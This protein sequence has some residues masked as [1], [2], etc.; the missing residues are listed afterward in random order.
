MIMEDFEDKN[1]PR[2]IA[3]IMDGNGR[4][5]KKHALGR[6][7]GHRK[8]AEAVRRTVRACRNWGIK[9]LTLFAFSSE[10]WSRPAKEVNALM[11][12]LKEYIASEVEEIRAHDI[13]LNVIGEWQALRGDIRLLVEDAMKKTAQNDAMIW[14][15]ALSY[16]GRGEIVEAARRIGEDVAQGRILPKDIDQQLFTRYLYTYNLPDPDLLIRTSGEYRISNFLLWQSAYTEFYF[17]DVL[18]PDFS[19]E[20]LMAAIREYQRRERRFGQTTEQLKR[21]GE[22]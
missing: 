21:R 18:W 19:E 22:L 7:A 1:L 12:L 14:T 2:H 9:Y 3:I 8:G 16:G 20:D 13:R 10:N 11:R 15:I 6:V 5:A 4:W 17:T